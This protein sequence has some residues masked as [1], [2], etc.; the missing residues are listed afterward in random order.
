MD[1]KHIIALLVISLIVI[2]YIQIKD[3]KGNYINF[4]D[5]PVCFTIVFAIKQ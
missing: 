5:S 4:R 2:F 1:T 3:V